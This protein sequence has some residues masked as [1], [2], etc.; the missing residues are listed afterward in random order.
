MLDDV[1]AGDLAVFGFLEMLALGFVLEGVA[2]FMRADHWW[3]WSGS[4]LLGLLFFLAGIKWPKIKT[5]VG[6]KFVAAVEG[7]S[8]PEFRNLIIAVGFAYVVIS[9]R[10]PRYEYVIPYVTVM[11]FFLTGFE[12]IWENRRDLNRYVMPR[13]FTRRQADRLK[14]RLAEHDPYPV[15]VRV[16]PHDT[17]A[18]RYAQEI[19]NALNETAWKAELCKDEPFPLYQG[20]TAYGAG[21]GPRNQFG[22]PKNFLWMAFLMYANIPTAVKYDIKGEFAISLLVGPRPL[23]IGP[24]ESF[25]TKSMRRLMSFGQKRDHR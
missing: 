24:H 18:L 2:A 21:C 25:F 6:G 11:Y 14:K 7:L 5:V 23:I 17:E 22:E 4:L 8:R 15:S 16:N 20:L 9:R 1:P 13:H 10:M 19:A 3:K 12:Y